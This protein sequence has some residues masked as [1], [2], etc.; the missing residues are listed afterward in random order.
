MV[1]TRHRGIEDIPFAPDR[2]L[3]MEVLTLRWLLRKEKNHDLSAACAAAR[4]FTTFFV[5]TAG[6]GTAHALDSS[7]R[8]RLREGT[9]LHVA[10]GQV[11]QF[12]CEPDLD[13]ALVVFE[14]EFVRHV[15]ATAGVP[16]RPSPGRLATITALFDA[17]AR[18]FETF[19]GSER[20]RLLLRGLV[21]AV[22]L[23]F[24]VGPLPPPG[25]ALVHEFR[26]ALERSFFEAHEVAAYAAILRCSTA[27]R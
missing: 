10:P 20:A 12:G 3:R 22:G 18:E 4:T 5:V 7:L 9:V 26:A 11:Q 24:D 16:V 25:A 8:H 6:Q 23:A 13:A 1:K 19:D 2:P 21:E 27:A 17:T 14:P 15:P